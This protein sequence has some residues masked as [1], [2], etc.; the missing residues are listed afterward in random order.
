MRVYTN[1]M[2]TRLSIQRAGR[3]DEG[4]YTVKIKNIQGVDNSFDCIQNLL[5]LLEGHYAVHS[6]VT[7]TVSSSLI[8][9]EL[10]NIHNE[11]ILFL[12]FVQV[13]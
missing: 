3:S 11:L 2:G 6:P 5:S 12:Y 7:F 13:V 1:T 8:Q 10:L 4:Q 9:S